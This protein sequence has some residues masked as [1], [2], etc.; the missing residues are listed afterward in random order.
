MPLGLSDRKDKTMKNKILS[1]ILAGMM[2]FGGSVSAETRS[3]GYD[4][5]ERMSSYG[6]NLYIDDSIT[7][8]YIMTEALKK[9]IN[10]DP[11][12]ATKLIK[13]GFSSL[14][15]YSEYYTPE[16]YELFKK[17]LNR[18]VYGIGVVIQFVDGY[19]TVM[20]VVD[21]GGAKAAGVLPGDKIIKVDGVDVIGYGIDK[22]QDM[23]V[24]E[25]GTQVC[26]TFLR[27]GQEFECTI[28]RKEVLGQTVAGKIL[29]GNIGYIVI[30]NFAQNTDDEFAK[31]LWEFEQAGVTDIILDLRNN[32]GG[33]LDSA[34]GIAK[35]TV[36]EGPIV[37]TVFRDQY[38][39][40]VEM[41]TLKNPKYKFCVL[42]NGNSASAAEVL[43]SAMGES[44]V[45][46]LVGETSYGKGKSGTKKCAQGRADNGACLEQDLQRRKSPQSNVV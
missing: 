17:N 45:G 8:D 35:M 30:I 18:I 33:Y 10:E 3:P 37:T 40:G 15:E 5:F 16:E 41:S 7:T 27:E 42:I 29:E 11:E 32:P 22:V 46:Y 38:S 24:G 1:L 20:S 6:A 14:D 9:V 39:G 34:I 26:V 13:A 19:V 2:L 43:A 31:I 23:I 12:L 4:E 25:M 21:D 44:G 28:T 36:P